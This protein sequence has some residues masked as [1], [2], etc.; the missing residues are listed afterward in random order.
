MCSFIFL[1]LIKVKLTFDIRIIL[2]YETITCYVMKNTIT[3]YN[4][5]KQESN[6]VINSSNYTI[7]QITVL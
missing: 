4:T 1:P 5:F 2:L 6:R 3:I 7:A